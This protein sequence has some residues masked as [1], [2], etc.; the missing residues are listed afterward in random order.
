MH[1]TSL[2]SRFGNGD[3]GPGAYAYADWLARAGFSVWQMLPI[4][5]VGYGDSPYSSPSSFA[6]E[7]LFLALEPLVEQGLLSA[8]DLKLSPK[9]AKRLGEGNCDFAASRAFRMPLYAKAA[10]AFK[11]RNG[12]RAKSF[13]LFCERAAWLPAWL[14][15]VSAGDAAEAISR[16]LSVGIVH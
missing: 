14:D 4:G 8:A 2:P 15:F 6:I 9:D 5:P 12:E 1:L 7:P 3:L 10:A 16:P 11:S 13:K